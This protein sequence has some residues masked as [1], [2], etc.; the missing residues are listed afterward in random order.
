MAGVE[1]LTHRQRIGAIVA[2][3]AGNLVEWYDFYV[4]AFT[5]LFFASSFFPAGDRTAQLLNVAGV[6][7]AGF[8]IRPVGG[9]FFGRIADRKGRQ[10]SMVVSVL[11]MGGGS[12]LI[13]VAPTYAT[14]GAFA[15]ALLLL[16]RLI[17]GFSTGGE[18]GTAATYLSEVASDDHRGFYSSFQYVTLIGGQLGALLVLLTMQVFIDDAAMRAWGWRVP[19]AIGGVAALAVLIFRR[20]MHE[21]LPESSKRP[22]SGTLRELFRHP[23]S[24][25]VVV[26]LTAGGAL[27]LYTFTT[28]MQKF[29]VNTAGLPVGR[30]SIVMTWAMVGFMLFQPVMGALSDRIGRRKCLLLFA[31]LM[32]LTAV[33]ILSRLA[34]ATALQA[35]FLVLLALGILSF[36]SSISGLF[37]AELFPT[38]VRALGVAVAHSVAV[39]LFG[40]SAE[41]VALWFKRA[42]HEPYFF[43]YVSIVCGVSFLTA[44]LMGEPRRATM[45]D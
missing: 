11:L 40:G 37:K 13:A 10:A 21:T 41:Y 12:M 6:Y 19:F 44:L 17:Q 9:W 43:W 7:A 33:P 27:T 28:Y 25:F 24:L 15:P 36:Y 34:H 30:A 8:F 26:A 4:Y 38:H 5:A 45:Q 3:S 42:G 39:A 20:R 16:A 18:F 1:Q 35:F 32:S 2:G 29:L 22:G 23:R 31:G 14:I